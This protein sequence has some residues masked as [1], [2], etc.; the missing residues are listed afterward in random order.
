VPFYFMLCLLSFK[1]RASKKAT[2]YIYPCVSLIGM[3]QKIMYNVRNC[4]EFY[5][6]KALFVTFFHLAGMFL[7]IFS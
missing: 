5:G 2:L 6:L 3:V 4:K 1:G 7:L